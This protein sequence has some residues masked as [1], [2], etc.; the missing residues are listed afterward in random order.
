MIEIIKGVYSPKLISSASGAI[1]LDDADEEERLVSKGVAR[2]VNDKG[3]A[4]SK[5]N[6]DKA[7]DKAEDKANKGKTEGKKPGRNKKND[8]PVLT[9]AEPE[10]D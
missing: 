8:E 5:T 2:Y 9:A 4:K 3:E 6:K 7:E 10:E 1:S